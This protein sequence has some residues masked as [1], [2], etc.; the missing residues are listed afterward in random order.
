MKINHQVCSIDLAVRLNELD[1]PQISAF[2]YENFTSE[3]ISYRLGNVLC[4]AYLTEEILS[5]I[6]DTIEKDGFTYQ[7][8]ITKSE[9]YYQTELKGNQIDSEE[10]SLIIRDKHFTNLLAKLWIYLIKEEFIKY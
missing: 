4:S 10:D 9:G 3:V 6:P 1:S 5:H 8:I 2:F 7:L